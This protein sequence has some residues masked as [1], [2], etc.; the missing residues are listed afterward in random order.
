[1]EVYSRQNAS[2]YAVEFKCPIYNT[3]NASNKNLTAARNSREYRLLS[4]LKE[5]RDT[6]DYEHLY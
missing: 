6:V 3:L 2:S 1:M 5:K 4:D